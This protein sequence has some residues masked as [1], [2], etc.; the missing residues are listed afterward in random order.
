MEAKQIPISRIYTVVNFLNAYGYEGFRISG[1]ICNGCECWTVSR[2]GG[3]DVISFHAP[4]D[5]AGNNQPAREV[6]MMII[7]RIEKWKKSLSAGVGCIGCKYGITVNA[8]KKD[9][10]C[11]FDALGSEGSKP[12][13]R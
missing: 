11:F 1:K 3:G 4:P 12:C 13:K 8:Q 7:S 10:L 2:A 9:V 6:A 5:Q